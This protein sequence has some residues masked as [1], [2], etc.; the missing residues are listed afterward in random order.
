MIVEVKRRSH[1]Q[2]MAYDEFETRIREGE[3]QPET[4]VRFEVVTGPDFKPAKELELFQTLA[5]PALMRFRRALSEPGMPI[6]TA[7]LVGLQIRIYLGS[8]APG[9]ELWLQERFTNWAPAIFEQGEVYRLITYG[10][11]HVSLEH[12]LFNLLFLAYC[13][14]HL[15][16]ALGRL[17]LLLLFFGSVFTGGL[18]SMAFTPD[19]P[20]LG[21]SGGLFGLIAA[22]VVFGWKHFD[23]IPVRSRKYFGWALAPYLMVSLASGLRA[24]NVDNWGHLGGLIGGMALVTFLE[25]ERLDRGR[26]RNGVIRG[27]WA[28]ALVGMAVMLS[29]WGP[30][31]VPLEPLED[32]G[33]H[34]ERPAYWRSGWTFTGDRG[35]FSPTHQATMVV[36]TT[37][38]P[39]PLSVEDAVEGLL[40][41]VGSGGNPPVVVSDER[42]E[43]AVLEGLPARRIVLE[44]G[45]NDQQQALTA[46]V[47][48]R[49]VFEHRVL[50]Q[51]VADAQDRYLPLVERIFSSVYL[52]DPDEV[53]LARLKTETHPR[54]WEPAVDLGDALYRAGEPNQ[55][56]RSYE[57][58]L[59]MSQGRPRALVGLLRTYADYQIPGATGVARLSAELAP[60]S[61]AVIVAAADA[62]AS[63]GARDEGMMLLDR[64]WEELPGDRRLRRAR[65]RWGLGVEL[66]VVE[67][68]E[69]QPT[70]DLRIHGKRKWP[71]AV[72]SPQLW[73]KTKV[74]LLRAGS[75]E[76][77][78]PLRP[79]LGNE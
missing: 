53:M 3:I 74:P 75:A 52:S 29:L 34:V 78:T 30:H 48:A 4:L 33:W 69:V 57:R 46:L 68:E 59:E 7:V 56:L 73:P 40:E 17:N 49:G 18:M 6:V 43:L 62:L 31:M 61:P 66:P 20:S 65:L 39:R 55:A 28:T 72:W 42:V 8:F 41:R 63:E 38:H 26:R 23:D 54:S 45:L 35:W 27:L 70:D 10:L 64:A 16:R 77:R 71:I 44:F 5:N 15:E 25:P 9:A 1:V 79:R 36:T 13:G 12:L 21:A 51:T 76:R 58:A 2:R 14:Y 47:V 22:A 32:E 37:V 24:E 11:L 19:R 50:V 67:P 60:D